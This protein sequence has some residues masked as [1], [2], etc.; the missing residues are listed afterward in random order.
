M[1]AAPA[2]GLSFCRANGKPL[3][4]KLTQPLTACVCLVQSTIVPGRTGR[5]LEARFESDVSVPSGTHAL[6]EPEP[7]ILERHGLSAQEALLTVSSKHSVLIP[8]QNFCQSPV[9]LKE[10]TKLGSVE[11]V[12]QSPVTVQQSE[13]HV[14]CAP[15]KLGELGK[16]DD[17]LDCLKL[18]VDTLSVSQ[19]E[20][21]KQVIK[22]YS[23]VFA[24][25]RSELGCCDLVQHKIDTNGHSP[26][27]LQPYRIPVIRREKVSSMIQEMQE[28]G[29]V[30]PSSSPW[31]SPIV[32]VPKKDGSLRF[33]VDYRRL[34]SI[35]KKDV[36]PLPRIEDILVTLGK[37]KYFSTLDLASGYWQ[38][39][40]DPASAQKTAFTSHCGLH[41]FTRM[42][43]GLCN[44]PGTFQRL[45]QTV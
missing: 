24:L 33:C 5:F 18:P 41:E 21:I 23:D 29:V 14:Q 40:L 26:I 34:N 44:A 36:Y 39:K 27:K 6:F 31:S 4:S 35:T 2:L 8:V 11:S 22:E 13:V 7:G 16:Q 10:G 32:L 20:Q 45:M 1:N 3:T 28:Q 12:C 43:F 25:T 38:I 17:V 9:E 15:V 42:P 19:S 37:A 30:K